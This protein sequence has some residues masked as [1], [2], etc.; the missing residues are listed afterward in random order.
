MSERCQYLYLPSTNGLSQEYL[1][2]PYDQHMNFLKK[3]I[4]N[5]KK[6]SGYIKWVF[7]K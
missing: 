6:D 7:G 1:G 5:N 2:E 4:Q 3:A